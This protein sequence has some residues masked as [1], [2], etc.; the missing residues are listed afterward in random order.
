MTKHPKFVSKPSLTREDWDSRYAGKEFLWSVEPNRFLTRELAPYA[1]GRALDLAAGEG[2]NAV[3]LAEQGW[4]VQAVD[5]S[6]VAIE[7]ARQLAVGRNVSSHIA[8]KI[9]DLNWYAPEPYAFDL[10]TLLY[11]QLPFAQLAPILKRAARAVA[12]GG[13][14]LLVAHDLE[15]L[16]HGYGGPGSADV[17]YTA[18]QVTGVWAKD[19]EIEK[20]CRFQRPVEVD[21]RMETALDCLVMARRPDRD[22]GT[23][24]IN[25]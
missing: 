9:A 25:V 13:L 18:E 12:P 21:G 17:L 7:K 5:F 19:L 22:Q 23:R 2:R 1:P 14:V 16:T 6:P 3:W 4:T 24:P 15:N 10:V 8:F 11:L 20:A